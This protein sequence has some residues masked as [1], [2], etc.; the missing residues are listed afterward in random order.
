MLWI[1]CSNKILFKVRQ[2]LERQV[3]KTGKVIR[4]CSLN[5]ANIIE[6]FL[7][8]YH[9]ALHRLLHSVVFI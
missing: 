6:S 5:C 9:F 7:H 4:G 3:F 8:I 2:L 1:L